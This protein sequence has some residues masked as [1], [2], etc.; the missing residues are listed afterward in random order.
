ML[1]DVVV[2]MSKISVPY[3]L[4][5]KFVLQSGARVPGKVEGIYE[6][7]NSHN[8]HVKYYESKADGGFALLS[9]QS[10]GATSAAHAGA[11]D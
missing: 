8:F 10:L 4:N 6:G 5:G 3:T 9:S 7:L 2:T 11:V 1:A